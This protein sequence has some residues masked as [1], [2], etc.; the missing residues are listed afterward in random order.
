MT[1]A[2][3][4]AI[5]VEMVVA[6]IAMLVSITSVIFGIINSRRESRKETERLT[7]QAEDDTRWKTEVGLKLQMLIESDRDR[8][9]NDKGLATLFSEMQKQYLGHDHDIMQLKRD[10]EAIQKKVEQ[11]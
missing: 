9:A 10:V 8:A 5:T 3:G 4:T 1:A 2:E 11:K 7:R 6:L